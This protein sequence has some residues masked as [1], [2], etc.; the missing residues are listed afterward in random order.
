MDMNGFYKTL[1][2]LNIM[3]ISLWLALFFDVGGMLT[4]LSEALHW[5]EDRVRSDAG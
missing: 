2:A 4:P 1:I 5:L 3:L